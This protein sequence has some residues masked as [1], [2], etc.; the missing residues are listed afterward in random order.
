MSGSDLKLVFDAHPAL[1]TRLPV[2]A[3][4]CARSGDLVYAPRSKTRSA[5]VC[6]RGVSAVAAQTGPMPE[7]IWPTG[8]R[9]AHRFAMA[10]GCSKSGRRHDGVR[11]RREQEHHAASYSAMVRADVQKVVRSAF[12][13]ACA[14]DLDPEV[15]ETIGYGTHTAGAVAG[16]T[17]CV[18]RSRATTW[19]VRGMHRAWPE[20]G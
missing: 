8:N 13:R 12:T 7:E 3:D 19:T 14:A 17:H 18:E 11:Y 1:K 10:A 16:Q 2:L 15:A 5:R 9:R 20:T 6:M 4:V